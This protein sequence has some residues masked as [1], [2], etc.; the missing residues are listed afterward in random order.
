LGGTL[1]CASSSSCNL[2][3][4]ARCIHWAIPIAFW[5]GQYKLWW[6]W[7]WV[8]PNPPQRQP[9]LKQPSVERTRFCWSVRFT[10]G[11]NMHELCVS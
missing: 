11:L 8:N 6:V 9:K 2:I 4:W 7:T 3:H 1:P 10:K 5:Y